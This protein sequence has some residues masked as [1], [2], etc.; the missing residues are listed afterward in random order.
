LEV[1][2]FHY[3]A[4]GV[5]QGGEAVDRKKLFDLIQRDKMAVPSDGDGDGDGDGGTGGGESACGGG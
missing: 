4:L 3:P 1:C 5:S 2:H